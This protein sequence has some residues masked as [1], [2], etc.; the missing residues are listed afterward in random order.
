MHIY[1]CMY[2]YA[3]IHIQNE[4]KR[5]KKPGREVSRIV[6]TYS[7]D[8]FKDLV[9]DGVAIHCSPKFR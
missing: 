8:F 9:E 7:K 1:V 3:H 4:R 6:P 2:T 5:R